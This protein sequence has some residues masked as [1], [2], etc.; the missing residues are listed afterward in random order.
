MLAWREVS[1]ELQRA[2]ASENMKDFL[3]DG[4][5]SNERTVRR[6]FQPLSQSLLFM[7]MGLSV[8]KDHIVLRR[9]QSVEIV[10]SHKYL[11]QEG[12]KIDS[13]PTWNPA[14]TKQRK[15]ILII[16]LLMRS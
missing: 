3:G 6:P 5:V 16:E 10:P 7:G 1:S 11:Y 9:H 8:G 14:K 13:G 15:S 12:I 2:G 4:P